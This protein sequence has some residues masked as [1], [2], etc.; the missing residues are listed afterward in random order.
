MTDSK[1]ELKLH[2]GSVVTWT[3]K[4]GEDAARRYVDTFRKAQVIATRPAE[5]WGIFQ[6]GRNTT[7]EG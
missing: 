6:M 1:Y 2:N 3:G 4:D 7:I 5:M